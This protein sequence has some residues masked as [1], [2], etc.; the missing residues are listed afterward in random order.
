MDRLVATRPSRRWIGSSLAAFLLVVLTAAPALAVSWGGEVRLSGAMTYK[1]EIVRTGASSAL[2]TWQTGSSIYA[3]RTAD[4][5]R[6]W[7]GAQLL[8]SG[9]GLGPSLAGDGQKVDLTYVKRVTAPDGGAAWRLFYRRSTNGGATW[10]SPR[11]LTS[12]SSQIADQDVARHANGQV[13]VVWTGLY[14]GRLYI[15]T[16]TDG[17]TTFGAARP[18]GQTSNWEPGA[19]ITYRADAEIA[20]GDGVTY[21][22]YTSARDILS[23]RRSRDRGVTWSSP[24]RLGIVSG[25]YSLAAGGTRA[26]LGYT[27]LGSGSTRAVYRRTFDRGATWSSPRPLASHATG[28]FSSGPRFTYHSGVLAVL[29]KH[30]RA[31]ASPV[32]HRQTTDL[33][34]S[35]SPRTRVS[36]AHGTRPDPEAGGV[37]VLDGPQVAVY[38]ENGEPGNIGLW[39]RRTQ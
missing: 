3:R 25:R 14:S 24:L 39:A 2:V 12:A 5:G 37:A 35:W 11:A 22:A 15:R 10:A 20:V 4:G 38:N 34:S 18:A 28:E 19:R 32:W 6:T 27:S 13:S 23:V 8:A 7:S 29:F 36:V 1:P 26:V 16:S 31:G 17:G 33:G 21:L 9:I 30:G